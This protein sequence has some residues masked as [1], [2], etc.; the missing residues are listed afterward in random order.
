MAITFVKFITGTGT[1]E[2]I[3]VPFPSWP[4]P[5]SPQAQTVPSLFKARVCAPPIK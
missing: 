5:F 3:S 2:S 1:F 4:T